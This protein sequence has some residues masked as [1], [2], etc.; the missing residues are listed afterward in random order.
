M[1][2]RNMIDRLDDE[3]DAILRHPMSARVP[4]EPELAA[5]W[6]VA[7]DL[8]DL[9]DAAFRARLRQDLSRRSEAMKQATLAPAYRPAGF[10]SITPYLIVPGAARLIEFMREAFGAEELRRVPLPDGSLQHAEVRIGDA[11][12]ELADAGGEWRPSP[13]A[14]HFYVAD[15]DRTYARAIA[16]GAAS[17]GAPADR[18]YGERSGFVADR[19]GNHWYIATRLEGPPIPAGLSSVTTHLTVE[20]ADGLVDFVARAFGA[21]QLERHDGPDGRIVHAKVKLG[22]SVVELGDAAGRVTPMPASLHYYVEDVDAVY[23]SAIRAG[24]RSL[25]APSDRPYGDRA[26]E[27]VDA[28]GNQWF[29]ATHLGAPRRA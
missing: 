20:G 2:E 14:L 5:L 18:P 11:I 25:G 1:V 15:A 24:A 23:A 19:S 6:R 13:A 22:D 29:I 8:L 9:P 4:S 7:V 21:E 17:L 26:S 12:V 10:R 16:A 28:F 3:V 27:V